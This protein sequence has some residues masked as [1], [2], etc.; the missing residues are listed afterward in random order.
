MLWTAHVLLIL[1]IMAQNPAICHERKKTDEDGREV[2]VQYPL[3]GLKCCEVELDLEGI[4]KGYYDM[5]PGE[6]TDE[7]LHDGYRYSTAL[8]PIP[9]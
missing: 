9:M 4:E 3:V 1:A 8:L 7:R 5:G 2:M 6:A